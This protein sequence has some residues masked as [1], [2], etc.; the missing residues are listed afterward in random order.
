MSFVSK[1]SLGS[2]LYECCNI[3]FIAYPVSSVDHVTVTVEVFDPVLLPC[4]VLVD[5]SVSITWS[6]DGVQLTLPFPGFQLL[7]NGSLYIQSITKTQDGT[8]TCT[9]TNTLGSIDSVVEL[10]VQ[11][12]TLY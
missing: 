5:E 7:Q 10:D 4:N 12:N 1:S 9:G 11:G 8:Y 3:P 2:S 6:F